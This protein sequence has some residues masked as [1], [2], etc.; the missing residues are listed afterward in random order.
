MFAVRED[1]VRKRIPHTWSF[2]DVSLDSNL[3]YAAILER[4]L[5]GQL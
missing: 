5:F 4:H 1:K 2:S 3:S